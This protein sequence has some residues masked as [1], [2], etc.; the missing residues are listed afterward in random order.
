MPGVAVCTEN[1]VIPALGIG[2]LFKGERLQYTLEYI[3]Q[4]RSVCW[5]LLIQPLL[6]YVVILD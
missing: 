3:V 6:K 2:L 1:V 5:L 4:H